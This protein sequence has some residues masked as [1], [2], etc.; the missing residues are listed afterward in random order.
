MGADELLIEA[1]RLSDQAH[2]LQNQGHFT[3]AVPLAERALTL[4]EQTLRADD[5]LVA[6]S[7][8]N[9]GWL[10]RAEGRYDE[11][12]PLF[13]R[14]IVIFETAR[15][16]DDP[17]TAPV[18]DNLAQ[19]YVAKG[20]YDE[21]EPLFGRALQLR[22]TQREADPPAL[23]T[24]LANLATFDELVGSF[25]RAEP[26]YERALLIDEKALGRD[27]PDYGRILGKLGC[28]YRDE[29][30]YAESEPL[31]QRS[32]EILEKA[33]GPDHRDVG[34]A[35]NELATLYERQ[36]RYDDAE[37]LIKRSL[38]VAQRTSGSDSLDVATGE[39]NLAAL[40]EDEGHDEEAEAPYRRAL[41]IYQKVL[42]PD[43]PYVGNT[44]DN[45][46]LVYEKQGHLPEAEPLLRQSLSIRE[47]ALGPDHPEVAIGLSNLAGLY[48]N[49]SRYAEAEPLISRA[50]A[51]DETT[52][53]PD[54]PDVAIRLQALSTL[55]RR[56]GPGH[57]LDALRTASRAVAI[58][59]KH[60]SLGAAQRFGTADAERR[61]DRGLF[62]NYI[63]IAGDASKYAEPA[64]QVL[65]AG[66]TFRVAQLAQASSVGRAVAGMAARF[67]AGS[68]ALAAAIRQRQDLVGQWQL[69]NTAI[70]RAASRPPAKDQAPSGADLRAKLD[71]VEQQITALDQR[72]AVQFPDY[73]GLSN[74]RPVDVAAA[75]AL[76]DDDEAL[77]VYLTADEGTWLWVVRRD[78]ITMYPLA[79][80][81]ATLAD[82][83]SALRAALDPERNAD[84]KPY[85][86]A[87]AYAL[88][89]KILAPAAARLAGVHRLLVVTDGALQSLP[90]SVLVSAPPDHAPAGADDYRALAWLMRDY[91]LTT[92]PSVSSLAALRQLPQLARVS[93]RFLG[94]GDPVL[95]G[96]PGGSP[97]QTRG[98]AR[99]V[100]FRGALA[101]VAE[102]RK[103]PPLPETADELR[104]I[105]KTLGA[106][107]S[108]LLLAARASEPV[109]RQ[110]PLAQFRII[111]FAT[112]G[113]VSGD[114]PGLAEPALV[115]TP[116]QTATAEDDG[117]LTASKIATLKLDADW[118]VLSACN[119]AAPDGAPDAEGLSGLAKAFFYAGARSIL[120]SHWQVPSTATVAL[121]TAAFARLVRDPAIGR[122]EALRQSE[123]AMLD[124]KNPPEFANP[125]F[126]APFVLA[127]EGAPNR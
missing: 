23:A 81:P 94:V 99:R 105:A 125:M 103:L 120:V 34:V 101:D 65:L 126:W 74:P 20:R 95:D 79:V 60:L 49:Q 27:A 4:R 91:A 100:L 50:L 38:M 69:L 118:V 54:H 45:L 70:D 42:G 116:P 78:G 40:Y 62:A 68:D 107:D 10:Y 110:M 1:Q 86:A 64:A 55:Y 52:L 66:E 112:H 25:A 51:I 30:R 31:L 113:L 77:L 56:E 21:A 6:T 108:D 39:N 37:A 71:G 111:D 83:V 104:R 11:A 72:I 47:A 93:T 53:G 109:L 85:P 82:Q 84:L 59:T 3:E 19:L 127:G 97:G 2:A 33:L 80:T 18:L 119:T 44:L 48:I 35:L 22:E 96:S 17:G 7:A 89:Q 87:A 36:G 43:H 75:Q 123:L 90:L 26:L 24:S 98:A 117:L 13:K 115:L 28:L 114:L 16:H 73:A 67:A 57:Y 5:P 46:G 8:N 122:A 121:T 9:L 58:I 32:E 106:P 12:E 15:G 92:L 76:L 61:E 63:A 88:Y 29:S 102:V 124:P 14:A 41:A